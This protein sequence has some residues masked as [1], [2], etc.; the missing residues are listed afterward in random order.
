M[1]PAAA[2]DAA[3]VLH[4]VMIAIRT[5]RYPHVVGRMPLQELVDAFTDAG[6]RI[7]GAANERRAGRDCAFRKLTEEWVSAVPRLAHR[8]AERFPED[9]WIRTV[10][11]V[12][13][14]RPVMVDLP[15]R[16]QLTLA[17][18]TTAHT[19]YGRTRDASAVVNLAIPDGAGRWSS[20]AISIERPTRLS[21]DTA[22]F[23]TPQ[24]LSYAP[25]GSLSLG[26]RTLRVTRHTE[27]EIE[28]PDTIND[29]H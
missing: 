3:Q 24:A 23:I 27:A 9:H 22:A 17:A 10:V 16:A 13:A 14:S 7:L 19:Q 4:H 15:D 25:G 29:R 11:P 28:W 1:M 2:L 6:T 20:Q 12:D 26:D 21:L 8:I 18:Y 5:V